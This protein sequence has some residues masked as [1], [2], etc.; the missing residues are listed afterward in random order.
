MK[1][2]PTIEA[3]PPGWSNT[4]RAVLKPLT[5]VAA[6]GVLVTSL[7]AIGCSGASPTATATLAPEVTVAPSPEATATSTPAPAV[8]P[9]PF[10]PAEATSLPVPAATSRPAAVSGPTATPAA[11]A[12]TDSRPVSILMASST[13]EVKPGEDFSVDVKV[14]PQERGI[15]GV[16]VRI[17]YDPATLRVA[18]AQPG[19]LLGP[20]PAVAGPIIDEPNGAVEY[21]AAR[22]GPTQPPTA[23]GLF[24]TLK[25]Q[26]LETASPGRDAVLEITAVK[27]PDENV[28]EI[29]N[30]LIGQALMVRISAR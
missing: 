25:F 4:I 19:A 14:D 7:I 10:P 20:E 22:I 1:D 30:V 11:Q 3:Q 18:G 29:P 9:S 16:Q 21:A 23:P 24:A 8:T 13:E 27:V 2:G 17:E 5:R 15:S 26:V 12:Q 28:R 6:V